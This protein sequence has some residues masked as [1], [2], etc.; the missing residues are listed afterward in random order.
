MLSAQRE[1]DA[2]VQQLQESA[3]TEKAKSQFIYEQLNRAVTEKQKKFD[4]VGDD[5]LS[6]NYYT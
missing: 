5:T 1:V 4:E 2:I 3:A 6:N